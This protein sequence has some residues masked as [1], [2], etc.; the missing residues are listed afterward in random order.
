MPTH[1]LVCMPM[2]L[3]APA[4]SQAPDDHHCTSP[5]HVTSPGASPATHAA[6]ESQLH[7]NSPMPRPHVTTSSP[8][9]HPSIATAYSSA[10]PTVPRKMVCLPSSSPT[11]LSMPRQPGCRPAD[12]PSAF[13][14]AHPVTL[15][16][17]RY[18]PLANFL[19]SSTSPHLISHCAY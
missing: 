6:A 5:E 18:R 10:P 11:T 16:C 3:L 9:T 8:C 17:T 15:T 1:A 13:P 12:M 19:E 2:H 7:S 14:L 4:P